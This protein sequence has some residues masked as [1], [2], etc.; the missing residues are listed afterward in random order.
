MEANG[1]N[2]SYALL[3]ILAAPP[4]D[5]LGN[6]AIAFA[7][8]VDISSVTSV[9]VAVANLR[10]NLDDEDVQF[11]WDLDII[12]GPEWRQVK[13]VA[14]LVVVTGNRHPASSRK[15]YPVGLSI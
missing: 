2:E 7:G 5:G 6:H 3:Q 13:T 9:G 4:F 1:E 8:E 11:S 15:V 10:N 12:V 14:P